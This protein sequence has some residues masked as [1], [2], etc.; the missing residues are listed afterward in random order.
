M[1]CSTG[2]G[3]CCHLGQAGVCPYLVEHMAGRRWACGLYIEHGSW[4]KV[5]QDQRYQR[6]VQSRVVPVSTVNCGDW[7]PPGER[8]HE[9]G[10]VG[11]EQR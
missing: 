1:A 3:H 2:D 7:P 6:D 8:C 9:C 5:H 11:G 4:S 10:Q